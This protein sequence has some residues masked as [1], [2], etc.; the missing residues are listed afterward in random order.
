MGKRKIKILLIR[1]INQKLKKVKN[2]G[3]TKFVSNLSIWR[4]FRRYR[5]WIERLVK[6]KRKKMGIKT[7]LCYFFVRLERFKFWRKRRCIWA[8]RRV[9][10]RIFYHYLEWDKFSIPASSSNFLYCH[11]YPYKDSFDDRTELARK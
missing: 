5:S 8:F 10:T 2:I 4:S 3:I 11:V 6:R 7:E 9:H 1:K